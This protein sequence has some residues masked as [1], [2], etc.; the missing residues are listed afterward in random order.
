MVS[1]VEDIQEILKVARITPTKIYLYTADS[2]TEQWKWELFKALKDVPDREKIKE[3]MQ[4]RKDKSTVNFVK[5][6]LKSNLEY[7]EVREA[8]T[9][10]RDTGY[11]KKAFGCEL[12]INEDYDPKGKKKFAIPL[13][14]A[15][16][17]E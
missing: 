8:E 5:Q 9:L 7:S 1:L 12:S 14:P 6:L 4:I 15:I 2:G 17:V 13:K 3:A 10:A 11:L 16:Y